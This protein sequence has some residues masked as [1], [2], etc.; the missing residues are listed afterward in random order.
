MPRTTLAGAYRK[1]GL[2]L[3]I[4]AGLGV[5]GVASAADNSLRETITLKAVVP[6]ICHADFNAAPAPLGQAIVPLGSDSEFCNAGA[7]Y[8]VTASYAGGG[9][10]GSLIVDGRTV[11]LSPSGQTV[12]ASEPGPAVAQ[13]QIS[14]VPG[15]T[16]IS[17]LTVSVLAG[18][19]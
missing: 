19:I 14:Y 8:S 10:P 16:P 11:A 18:A 6:V 3:L 2:A 1:L 4:G 5:A 17:T 9:D 12:I 7:G 13:R 15:S